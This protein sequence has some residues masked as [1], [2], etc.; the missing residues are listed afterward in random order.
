MSVVATMTIIC[1]DCHAQSH[2]A[3][4]ILAPEIIHFVCH[5]CERVVTVPITAQDIT[6][7]QARTNVT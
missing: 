2:L 7:F 4:S 1:G 3:R 5:G 6:D